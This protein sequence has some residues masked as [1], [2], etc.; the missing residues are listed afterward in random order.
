MKKNLEKLSIIAPPTF[1]VCWA[2][3][4][5]LYVNRFEYFHV[6]TVFLFFLLVLLIYLTFMYLAKKIVPNY[7]DE[8]IVFSYLSL[9]MAFL[10]PSI[11][12]LLDPFWRYRYTLL[13]ELIVVVSLSYFIL[14]VI[15]KSKG[16]F[17][18]L[19]FSVLLPLIPT[20][21]YVYFVIST[22]W[23]QSTVIEQL[24]IPAIR[25]PN[26]YFFLTDAYMRSDALKKGLNFDNSRMMKFLDQKKFID[27]YN[28]YA[29][30]P[31]TK[32]SLI[33]T[34]EMDHLKV[35]N[36]NIWNKKYQNKTFN[37]FRRLGY[38]I[39]F[40]PD[41]RG[42]A[43]C[44]NAVICHK[45]EAQRKGF[46]FSYLGVML[47]KTIPLLE[48]FLLSVAPERFEYE[49]NE[50]SDLNLAL[51]NS[52]SNDP[53]FF[54]AHLSMPHPPY[55]RDANCRS[56]NIKDGGDFQSFRWANR[57][58][59]IDF[60]KCGNSQ[61][62]TLLEYLVES[63]PDAI[64]IVQGD[65]GAWFVNN[66]YSQETEPP[67][68]ETKPRKIE[69]FEGAYAVMNAIRAPAPCRKLIYPTMSPVN[70]FRMVFSCLTGEEPDYVPDK[71]FVV[72]QQKTRFQLIRENGKWL[73]Q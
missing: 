57:F 62:Q 72:N 37:Y 48:D 31:M 8:I 11:R 5:F 1:I 21:Q 50:V 13:L 20:M 30:Y 10:T 51:R 19:V 61:L 14:K 26:V 59:Y 24:E 7:K 15:D 70:T 38:S 63:D 36:N 67:S 69:A 40:M 33:S 2:C 25:K 28:S 4:N 55:I 66:K 6:G 64:I 42:M 47:L 17:L 12:E 43:T 32:Y 16:V 44:H 41:L 49:L 45:N 68:L 18:F 34:L 54:F 23:R 65:H 46:Y 73:I 60:L 71:S 27:V 22:D 3:A 52:N 39:H 35:P 29:A 58:K 56:V 53:R 9:F